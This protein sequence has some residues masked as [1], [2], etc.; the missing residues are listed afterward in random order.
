MHLINAVLCGERDDMQNTISSIDHLFITMIRDTV[1]VFNNPEKE[2]LSANLDSWYE[3][4][5][6]LSGPQTWSQRGD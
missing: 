2:K 1:K 5:R 4:D 3:V 6:K